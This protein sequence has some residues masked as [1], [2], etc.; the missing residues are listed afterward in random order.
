MVHSPCGLFAQDL[1]QPTEASTEV[2]ENEPKTESDNDQDVPATDNETI[3]ASADDRTSMDSDGEVEE[4]QPKLPVIGDYALLRRIGAGGMGRVF[5]AQ[6]RRMDRLVAV[7]IL[8]KKQMGNPD[9]VLRFHQEMKAAAKLIHPNIVTAFDAGEQGGIHYLVMEF[10]DGPSLNQIIK[11][12]GPLTPE[13]AIEFILQAAK[14][15]SYSHSCGMIHRDIKPSNLIQDVD[16]TVKILD[17]GTARFGNDEPMADG[18]T[19]EGMIMGTINYMAP[20][21]ARDATKADHRSD[22]YSLGCTLY[23]LM[24][25][26]SLYKGKVVETLIA[27]A[28]K[29]IPSLRDNCDDVPHWL[30]DVFNKMVAKKP[31]D[32]YQNMEEMIQDVKDWMKPE[33]DTA[34]RPALI[35]DLPTPQSIKVMPI[36]IDLGTSTC[37]IAWVNKEGDPAVIEDTQGEWQ[38]ASMVSVNG[39]DTVIG[40]MVMKQLNK[41]P[42]NPATE[43]K[44]FLGRA[45]YPEPMAGNRYHPETLLG[46]LLSKLGFDFQ[47]KIG[48]TKEAVISTPACFDAVRRKAIQHVGFIAGLDASWLVAEPVAATLYYGYKNPI[49]GD[50]SEKCLVLDL[51]GGTLDVVALERQAQQLVI[52]AIAGDTRLGGR[53]WDQCMIELVSDALKQKHGF[54]PLEDEKQA[55]RLWQACE[56]A[57]HM[58]TERDEVTVKLQVPSGSAQIV[59]SRLE[60][61]Q[62]SA[63]LRARVQTALEDVL[64]QMEWDNGELDKVIFCGGASRMPMIASLV[65]EVIGEIPVVQLEENAV[66]LG[67]AL[68]A[69]YGQVKSSG[70]TPSQWVQTTNCYSLGV[71]SHEAESGDEISV[72]VIP[73]GTSIPVTAR[74][75]FRTQTTGQPSVMVQLLEGEGR[76][77]TECIEVGQ[78]VIDGLPASLPAQSSIEVD[79][80]YDEN[81]CLVIRAAIPG[82][83]KKTIWPI[84]REGALSASDLHR[85]R[86]WV[87]TVM[88]CSSIA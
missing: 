32:R 52:A 20:E 8:S 19:E 35:A 79:I 73:R 4:G 59:I 21:Q 29:P 67:A 83:D 57:K 81:G 74:Q 10:V 85:L 34:S 7:K 56:W 86:E 50:N 25:G 84:N 27:H 33:E 16:G 54:D 60:F 12:H 71:L 77:R 9:S 62:A 82:T 36:G 88:L 5:K 46:L 24:T 3:S 78:C 80:R 26:K 39:M 43:I 18:L 30:E 69:Y 64:Q 76:L 68:Y 47:R 1:N 14:G 45:Y 65:Q 66:V 6:H 11:N 38:T 41:Q 31:E 13:K 53:D 63:P 42:D 75:V 44:R 40:S 15:L 72:P 87:E 23:F 55:L 28:Q 61:E 70:G 17:M 48:P 2:A 37:S 22:I 51:G 58:L 49:A